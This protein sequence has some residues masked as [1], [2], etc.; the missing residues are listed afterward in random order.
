MKMPQRSQSAD[1]PTRR[2]IIEILNRQGKATVDELARSLGITLMAVRLHLVV[3]ERDGLVGRETVRKGPGRPALLFSLT[4]KAH[5]ELPKSYHL[6]ADKL[7]EGMEDHLTGDQL[8]QVCGAVAKGLASTHSSRM[9]GLPLADKV[10]EASQI[11]NEFGCAADWEATGDG[12]V[13]HE[14]NCPYFR[15][16]QKHPQLCQM[17]QNFMRDLLDADV[18]MGGRLVDQEQHCTYVI[19]PR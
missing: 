12:F 15:V 6:L 13:I 10:A 8:E 9:I 7:L 4:D 5:D 17:D 11:L 16:A 1:Q 18:E 19:R 2:Q 14:Y 3:L